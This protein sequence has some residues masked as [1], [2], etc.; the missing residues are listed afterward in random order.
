[1]DLGDPSRNG[2]QLAAQPSVALGYSTL[3]EA[4]GSR[5]LCLRFL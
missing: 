5:R 3:G 1:M 4:R 2:T